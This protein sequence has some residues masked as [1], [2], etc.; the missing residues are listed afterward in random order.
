MSCSAEAVDPRC[1]SDGP[2]SM[3]RVCAFCVFGRR[4]R[5]S[6]RCLL[7]EPHER[8]LHETRQA[9]LECVIRRGPRKAEDGWTP[10]G[11]PRSLMIPLEGCQ[12]SG[13]AL[14]SRSRR[15]FGHGLRSPLGC[16][17][18][19]EGH[20]SVGST[21][22]LCRS[23]SEVRSKFMVVFEVSSGLSKKLVSDVLTSRC[24]ARTAREG[25]LNP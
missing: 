6:L 10:R 24:A 22:K 20:G 4:G 19:P 7:F 23:Y 15:G 1:G 12:T 21:Q 13:E 14:C 18:R 11:G 9:S 5:Y 25:G 16:P 2:L 8:C 17:E 3:W